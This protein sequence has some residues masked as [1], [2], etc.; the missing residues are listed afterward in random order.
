MV[1]HKLEEYFTKH[2]NLP[3]CGHFDFFDSVPELSEINACSVW[4]GGLTELAKDSDPK[5]EASLILLKERY[6]ADKKN[7]ALKRYWSNRR[8]EQ[9]AERSEK[10]ARVRTIITVN[11]TTA[12]VMH[13]AEK[14]AIDHLD[15]FNG[16]VSQAI[17]RCF[18]IQD[19]SESSSRAAA[20]MSSAPSSS[21]SSSSSA[22]SFKK[23]KRSTT[24]GDLTSTTT[25]TST[26]PDLSNQK[27]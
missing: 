22:P 2:P 9:E 12:R 21:S 26:E 23:R 8:L 16:P 27:E 14:N 10:E 5:T 25:T 19:N 4:I 11:R 3:A 15:T 18:L 1:H 24:D 17:L 13:S 6:Y 20:R 7:G